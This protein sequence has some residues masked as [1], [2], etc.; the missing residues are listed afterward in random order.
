MHSD[1]YR[2]P[3]CS[4]RGPSRRSSL[5]IAT[6][7]PNRYL[8]SVSRTGTGAGAI[9]SS[10]DGINCGAICSASYTSDSN[11]T[12]VVTAN[13]GSSFSGWSGAC[14]GTGSCV[15]TMSAAKNVAAA[16][17]L[18]GAAP[19]GNVIE[20]YN[21]KLDHYF[22]TASTSEA[23]AIDNGGAG[24]GWS[25]T[26]NSFKSGGSKSVCRFYG[27]LSPGPNSHFYTVDSGECTGL[28][29]QQVSTPTTNK[30]WNFESLD[31]VS[32]APVYGACPSGTMPVY[33]AY[34][35]GASR[36]VDSNHRLVSSAAAIQEVVMRGWKDE[37]IAMC[38]PQ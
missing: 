17:T 12:L 3:P 10:P 6:A 5:T 34:N 1:S 32:T 13:F 31:F 7:A 27:S 29:Q 15:V 37:G 25:R 23:A 11:I 28:T 14:T 9:T 21:S 20:F 35:N 26:G 22:I 36:G 8:L 2:S 18:G 4:T 30:R 16:F 19:T 33:R 24:S 38:A